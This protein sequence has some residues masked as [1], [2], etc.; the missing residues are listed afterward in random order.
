[1][2]RRAEVANTGSTRGDVGRKSR[3]LNIPGFDLNKKGI[4][5]SSPLTL[6]WNI[7]RRR[8]YTEYRTKNSRP[9]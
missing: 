8:V 9:P 6:G 2:E 4:A 5:K 7:H 1:M 3:P